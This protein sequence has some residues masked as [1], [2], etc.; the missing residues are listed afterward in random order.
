MWLLFLLLLQ[1]IS[2]V[3]G[4]SLRHNYSPG[5]SEMVSNAIRDKLYANH[6]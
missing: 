4:L 3:Y 6:Y 1:L 2:P 5:V